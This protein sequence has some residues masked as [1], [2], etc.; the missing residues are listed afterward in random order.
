[1]RTRFQCVFEG[2]A[3]RGNPT[4]LNKI[5]TELY[6]TEGESGEVNFEHE[7]RQIETAHRR[8]DIPIKI[9]D[10]FKQ[11]AE[12]KTEIRTVL[13][14]G[15]AGIG[16]TV[17]VHKFILDWA[18]ERA[19][20][21]VHLIFPLP[22]REL[23]LLK[24]THL[25][26]T[27]I[28]HRFFPETKELSFSS[29]EKRKMLF[30]FDGLDECRLPLNFQS[31]ENVRD[32]TVS[33]SIDTLL[34]NLIKG[35]LLPSAL[36]WITSRPGAAN[37]IPPECIDRLTE[38]RGFNDSQKQEYFRR[39]IT[40]E[41]HASKIITHI[42][43]SRSLFIMCHIPVFCW[44]LATVFESVLFQPDSWELP[45]TLTQMY[46]Y[47]LIFQ[48][49]QKNQK[50]Y[51]NKY[52]DPRFN[53][54][55]ILLLGKL[56]FQQLEKGNIIFYEEDIRECG[57]DITDASV[58]SGVFTQIFREE[59]G[60]YLGKVYCFVHLSIQEFLAALYVFLKFVNSNVNLFS[61]ENSFIKRMQFRDITLLHKSVIDK[62]LASENGH[63][64]LFVR[65][66][67]GLSSEPNQVL[68]QNLL[69]QRV[70]NM[71]CT[72]N[73]LTYIKNIIKMNPSPEKS[74]NLFHCLSELNDH[75]LV[76]EV[77]TF[78]SSGSLSKTE[79]YPAHWSALVFLLRTSEDHMDEFDLKKY[80]RSE[81]CLLRLLPAVKCAKK[82][83]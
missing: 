63:L 79:L 45:K 53:K 12:E 6:I 62:A 78:L 22:F 16:K 29:N 80:I 56:A 40:N 76:Q 67:L 11:M 51:G 26:L 9:N 73:T 54:K 28:L 20:Q 43:S 13:T 60:M 61:T 57:I 35:N 7:T 44:I 27:D 10:M 18:D 55:S 74:I 30:I 34:T 33:S 24:E 31:N 39:K 8:P 47:F 70:K 82:A 38:I 32:V 1:M 36:I 69:T 23:N 15:V 50:Y 4:L 3:K 83:L 72:T 2:R 17:S 81:E 37:S 66:L 52:V 14:M 75:T 25:S 65:F 46:I 19:N 49:Q 71:Q 58:Y 5:Y 59:F 41:N 64:D 21:D 48:T 42:K 68:L 77:Q